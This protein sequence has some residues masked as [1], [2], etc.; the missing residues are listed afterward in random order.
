M[1]KIGTKIAYD[2]SECHVPRT[3]RAALCLLLSA[4]LYGLLVS[5]GHDDSCV[6]NTYADDG[7]VSRKVACSV[8][9][10]TLSVSLNL[11]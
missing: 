10:R 6:C 2:S 9:T 4:L 5:R 8:G 1:S 7:I 11:S 3:K